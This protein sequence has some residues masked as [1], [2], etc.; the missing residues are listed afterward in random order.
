M[1][2][3]RELFRSLPEDAKLRHM[4][5]QFNLAQSVNNRALSVRDFAVSLGFDVVRIPLPRGQAGRLERD[6]FAANG[7]RIEVNSSNSI[8]SQRWAVMHEVGHWLRHIRSNDLLADA[9]FLDRSTAAFYE[10]PRQE[11]EANEVAA[12]LFFGDG[13]LEAAAALH[14]YN[15]ATLAKRF[16][17][18]EQ[19]I[20]IGLEQ[21]CGRITRN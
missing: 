6:A 19:T 4:L 3:L 1:K 5:R 16:G 7:F 8:E 12:V 21:F 11:R 20:Q 15:V 10:D 17:L 2:T 9:M 18:S 14:D 13:V